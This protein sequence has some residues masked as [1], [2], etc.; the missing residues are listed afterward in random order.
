MYGRE[1]GGFWILLEGG[2]KAGLMAVVSGVDCS[3]GSEFI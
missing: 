1:R 2:G 3:E